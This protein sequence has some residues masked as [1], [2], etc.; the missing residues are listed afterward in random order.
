MIN[1]KKTLECDLLIAGGGAGGMQ[2]AIDAADAG[3]K[4]IVAE[5]ANTRRSGNGATGNDHFVCYI[6]EIHGSEENFI[7][8]LWHTQEA[9]GGKDIDLVKSFMRNSF[10]VV[11]AWESY[12]IPMRPH[13][14]W[15]FT[16]HCR[17]GVQGVHLKYAGLEQKPLLTKAALQ[18]GV[19]ILNRCPFTEI[20]TNDAGEVCGG[21]CVDLNG[22]KPEMQVV[23]AKTVLIATAGS[24]LMNGASTMGWMFNMIGCPASTGVSTAGAYRAGARLVGLD[25]AVAP[26]GVSGCKYFNRGGKATWVGVYTDIDGNPLGPFVTKPDWRYGDFTADFWP[27]MFRMN[28]QKGNPVFMNCSEGTDEDIEYM[29]WGLLHEGNGAT[30]QHLAD[31]G[32]DFRKHMVEFDA[33]KGGGGGKGVGIDTFGDGTTTVKGLYAA[34]VSMGNGMVGI[35]AAA[36]TGRI[37]ARSAAEYC[38]GRDIEEAEKADIVEEKAEHY[39]KLLENDASTGSPTWQE[40]II[41]I[42]QTMWDYLGSGVRSEKLFQVGLRHL[43]RIKDKINTVQCP[44]NHEFMRCLEAENTVQVAMLCME[45]SRSRKETRGAHNRVDYPFTHPDY[46]GKLMTVQK[47]D[48]QLVTGM[49]AMRK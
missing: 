24:M 16:G 15:E 19:T 29:K 23:R 41:A 46:D 2:A 20:I 13:G 48:G 27:G 3:L 42:Q 33:K 7:N 17:P 45:S 44:T 47:I 36:T 38:K 9:R 39:S 49:R 28:I 35:G 31:E 1:R 14:T 37:A 32:F 22:E 5:K 40:A 34:G 11:K 18:R 6:P 10:D 12:G 8:L 4:V 26:I 30:L 21:I 25:G 43:G